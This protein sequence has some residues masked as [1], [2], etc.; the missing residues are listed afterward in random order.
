LLACGEGALVRVTRSRILVVIV[1]AFAATALAF[2]AASV[3]SYT[4]A[5]DIDRAT[6][7]LLTNALPSVR[8]LARARTAVR[9]LRQSARDTAQA[10]PPRDV[11]E[12][13]R[14]WKELDGALTA[15]TAM[16]WYAGERALYEGQVRPALEDVGRAVG[17]FERFA[18]APPSDAG[19]RRAEERLEGATDGADAA[20]ESLSELNHE[21][22]FSAASWI[23]RTRENV[24]RMTLYLDIGST[25]IAL[26]AAILA[27]EFAR[28]FEKV[29]RRNVELET[30][31]AQEL[32]LVAQ[33]VAHDLMS[34]LAAVSLSLSS[35][36]RKHT[37][38]ETQHAVQRAQRVLERSRRM[39]Q[40][41]Y[42]FARSTARPT[43]EAVAPLRAAV[44]DAASAL[45]AVEGEGC[46]T[47]EVQDFEEVEVR[48]DRGM[49]D[50]VLSNLLSN[51]SK[52][53]SNA[54]VRRITVRA[55]AGAK[56]VYV[57]V[58]DTG[59]G[60]PEGFAQAIF[61][62]YKRAPGATQPGLGLGLATVKRLVQGHGGV[63]G[64][65]N[66]PS[67][68]AVFWF[69]LPRAPRRSPAAEAAGREGPPRVDVLHP[70][71]S[72]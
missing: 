37:D 15:E 17:D 4:V 55:R 47:V 48:M 30:E 22:A 65:H 68:G 29:M 67:G 59:P 72:G 6:S 21:E 24:A 50:V 26:I 12:L 57:E 33:R 41:I 10:R 38:V 2:L 18:G 3:A 44:L 56:S 66:A 51:A 49:L 28:H 14:H 20:V 13:D 25:L 71:P 5:S 54:P 31:R 60:V 11:G 34:P 46:P 23:V 43:G 27:I 8:Q 39:V 1:C 70:R 35:V 45:Q 58:E 62:P 52:F 40:G 9:Q 32:D 7:D 61:E 53:T 36:Q 69:E 63:V 42:A 19:L 16:P 64:V